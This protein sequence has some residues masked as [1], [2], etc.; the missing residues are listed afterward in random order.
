MFLT[1]DH[2][3]T[4]LEDELVESNSVFP[5]VEV[6][7]PTDFHTD[8]RTIRRGQWFV[9]IQGETFDGHAYIQNALQSGAAAYFYQPER[10]ISKDRDVLALGIAVKDTLRALQKVARG[11]RGE[12][13]NIK[14]V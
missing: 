3:R 5:A 13:K 7:K 6:P 12:L 2:Y 14:L 8:S 4:W 9:P 10:M 11:W 1:W